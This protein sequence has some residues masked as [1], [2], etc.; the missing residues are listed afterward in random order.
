[1][2]DIAHEK[3]ILI[4]AVETGHRN[5]GFTYF[6]KVTEKSKFPNENLKTHIKG[7]LTK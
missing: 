5:V 1:M 2:T 4:R 7:N 3:I 6:F